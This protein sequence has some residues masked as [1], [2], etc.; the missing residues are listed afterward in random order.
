MTRRCSKNLKDTYRHVRKR[1]NGVSVN[2]V[3][4]PAG[5]EDLVKSDQNHSIL[6]VFLHV[7][8]ALSELRPSAGG[9]LVELRS[10]SGDGSFS[11]NGHYLV[12]PVN[13]DRIAR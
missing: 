9:S 2:L 3:I 5:L 7:S 12:S 13:G 1:A 10:P 4:E 11:R 6:H 8:L